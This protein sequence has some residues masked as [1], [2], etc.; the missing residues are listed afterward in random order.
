MVLLGLGI[1]L[2]GRMLPSMF[3]VYNK[4]EISKLKKQNKIYLLKNFKQLK[5]S[6]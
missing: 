2:K 4:Q 3:K 5:K 1:E 6:N